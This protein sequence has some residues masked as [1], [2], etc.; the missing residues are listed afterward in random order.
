MTLFT[1]IRQRSSLL[2]ILAGLLVCAPML[3]NAVTKENAVKAGFVYNFT[4]FTVW[5]EGAGADANFNLCIVGDDHLDGSLEALYGK[6][7]AKKPL[8]LRRNVKSADLKSCHMAFI[9]KDDKQSMQETLQAFNSMPVLT[10]S[11]SPDFIENGGMIGLIRD[12]SR[13]GF[14][15]DIEAANAAGLHLGAQL[16]KLAKRVKGMK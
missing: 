7:A 1:Y 6:L 9:T 8:A 14:E 5:P 15:I 11:D 10:V 4:K 13:V 2:A 12:G 16:L 3:V